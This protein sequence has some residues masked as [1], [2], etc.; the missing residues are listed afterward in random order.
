MAQPGPHILVVIVVLD[1]AVN[2]V[3][4]AGRFIKNIVGLINQRGLRAE[5]EQYGM[6]QGRVVGIRLTDQDIY[7]AERRHI[8]PPRIYIFRVDDSGLIQQVRDRSIEPDVLMYMSFGTFI[9]VV[10]G[11]VSVSTAFR[12][13]RIQPKYLHNIEE[14]ERRFLTDAK[15][16]LEVMNKVQGEVLKGKH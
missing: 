12:A 4:Y 6:D 11:Q 15:M 3:V 10:T 2:K 5:R 9:K 7:E 8:F 1:G 13:A 16:V 14:Q